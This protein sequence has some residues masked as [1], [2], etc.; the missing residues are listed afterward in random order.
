[1]GYTG[2][3]SF[4][5][6]FQGSPFDVGVGN[7]QVHDC[8]NN[9]TGNQI[10]FSYIA[11]NIDYSKYCIKIEVFSFTSF[12]QSLV[13]TIDW[14]NVEYKEGVIN[15]FYSINELLKKYPKGKYR[16]R[17]SIKCCNES[18]PNPQ[19]GANVFSGT[20]MWNPPIQTGDVNFNWIGSSYT[21]TVNNDGNTGDNQHPN[22]GNTYFLGQLT[23]GVNW[24]IV[25]GSGAVSQ[26]K[27][28]IY[29]LDENCF[30]DEFLLWQKT[31][32]PVNGTLPANFQFNTETSGYFFTAA[33]Y[34]VGETCFKFEV[35][36]TG[37]PN[38]PSLKKEG[39]FRIA[40]GNP[41]GRISNI[42]DQSTKTA[43]SLTLDDGNIESRTSGNV[44]S[45]F[46]IYP[47]PAFNQLHISGWE[48]IKNIEL[49]DVRGNKQFILHNQGLMDVSTYQSGVYLLKLEKFDG[50]ISTKR[51]VK[52]L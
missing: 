49:I 26:V 45:S 5:P 37:S 2:G 20:F 47:N 9:P 32:T 3:N 36:V 22:D 16:F 15:P 12:T 24:N 51:F 8:G 28:R 27:T 19:N 40:S 46:E 14:S 29:Q 23:C 10:G 48:Q 4:T 42:Q 6:F 31:W 52:I 21:E 11:P 44:G 17:V 25:A 30:G 18:D 1:M 7:S 43:E 13:F 41:F 39:Y 35:E 38:C 33:G 34:D 50:T